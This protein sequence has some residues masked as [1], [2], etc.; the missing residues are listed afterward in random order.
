MYEKKEDG[1]KILQNIEVLK[2][3]SKRVKTGSLQM[4]TSSREV[5]KEGNNLDNIT[6][7]ITCGIEEASSGANQI[8]VAVE[9]VNDLSRENKDSA[10]VLNSEVGKFIIA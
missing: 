2:D 9:K 4:L 7:E 10:I 8:S 5:I 1:N 6:K 3:L